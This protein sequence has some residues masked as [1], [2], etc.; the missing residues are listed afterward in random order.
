MNDL[1]SFVGSSRAG[2]VRSAKGWNSDISPGLDLY[3]LSF[4]AEGIIDSR[5][6]V[7]R[8]EYGHTWVY[9][10]SSGQYYLVIQGEKNNLEV[11]AF[12]SDELYMGTRCVK[13]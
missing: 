12:S 4:A 9:V 11:N 10:A 2:D 3:G 1:I 7:A 5:G 8:G 13:D 6:F